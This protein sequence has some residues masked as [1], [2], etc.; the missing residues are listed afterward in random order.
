MDHSQ[1]GAANPG[2]CPGL[3]PGLCSA[4]AVQ[5]SEQIWFGVRIIRGL[6]AIGGLRE[7]RVGLGGLPIAFRVVQLTQD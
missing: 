6:Y 4:R 1:F 5:I 2:P 7:N 3:R